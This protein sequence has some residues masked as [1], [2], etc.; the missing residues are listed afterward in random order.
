MD[1][2]RMFELATGLAEAKSRQDVETALTFL[3][4]GMVL[5]SPAFGSRSVGLDENRTALTR[6]FRT[7]P[8]YEVALRGH[9]SDGETLV[10]W[11]D[12]RMTMT[13]D[14]FG[15]VPNGRRS[16]LPVFIA[17]TFQDDRIASE[18]FFFDLS[19][20]CAQS[21]VSADAVRHRLFAGTDAPAVADA[22]AG[23]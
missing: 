5:E 1:E 9:A 20:L 13:G 8:D 14:R 12:V 15:V 16:E 23:L 2:R 7:F 18:R 6:W 11:G 21:G 3:H 17:F 4:T 19:T 22:G 10:C